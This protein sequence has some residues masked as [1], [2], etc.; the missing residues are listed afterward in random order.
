MLLSF[1]EGFAG[2]GEVKVRVDFRAYGFERVSGAFSGE[3]I[4]SGVLL[5]RSVGKEVGF[6]LSFVGDFVE[7]D[8]GLGY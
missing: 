1:G 3:F 4:L 7:G 6:G 2:R 5:D 8:E